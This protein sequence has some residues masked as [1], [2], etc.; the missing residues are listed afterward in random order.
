MFNE[1]KINYNVIL[2]GLLLLYDTKVKKRW[3]KHYEERIAPLGATTTHARLITYTSQTA[4]SMAVNK[5]KLHV[6][7]RIRNYKTDHR[8]SPLEKKYLN[9]NF[10]L[11][12]GVRAKNKSSYEAC[13]CIYTN[14]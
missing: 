7:M 1:G 12:F 4:G 9:K 3:P 11:S 6:Y 10:T 8:T 13:T 14:A 2:P 5:K